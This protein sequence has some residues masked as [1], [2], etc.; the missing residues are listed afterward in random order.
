MED[1]QKIDINLE[2]PLDT[3]SSDMLVSVQDVKFAHN[4]QKFQGHVLPT[5]LR[6]ER[7]GWAAG[8]YVYDF[9]MGGG[10]IFSRNEEP[11]VEDKIEWLAATRAKINNTPTYVISFRAA[12]QKTLVDEHG[13]VI[14]N[15]RTNIKLDPDAVSNAVQFQAWH[16]LSASINARECEEAL[17]DTAWKPTIAFN[18]AIDDVDY[19]RKLRFDFDVINDTNEFSQVTDAYGSA[20]LTAEYVDRGQDGT[21][22]AI[23]NNND[24]RW[25]WDEDVYIPKDL[26]DADGYKFGK[27]IDVTNNVITWK[28]G[29]ELLKYNDLTHKFV[30]NDVNFNPDSDMSVHYVIPLT[31]TVPLH[32]YYS[33]LNNIT[34]SVQGNRILFNNEDQNEPMNIYTVSAEQSDTSVNVYN[35]DFAVTGIQGPDVNLISQLKLPIN[36]LPSN[37]SVNDRQTNAAARESQYYTT[38]G[39]SCIVPIFNTA[40]RDFKFGNEDDD[41]ARDVMIQVYYKY[42]GTPR[43]IG[44]INNRTLQA[45]AVTYKMA[46]MGMQNE[47]VYGGTV[48]NITRYNIDGTNKNNYENGVNIGTK[49]IW[50]RYSELNLVLNEVNGVTLNTPVEMSMKGITSNISFNRLQE[51]NTVTK[52][53]NTNTPGTVPYHMNENTGA[54]MNTMTVV[55]V[56]T[57][58]SHT[59]S[60]T[61]HFVPALNGRVHGVTYYGDQATVPSK[62]V[63]AM[64]HGSFTGL[65]HTVIL[66][67]TVNNK[68]E[69]TFDTRMQRLVGLEIGNDYTEVVPCLIKAYSCSTGTVRDDL[70]V[71][72]IKTLWNR[73]WGRVLLCALHNSNEI[74]TVNGMLSPAHGFAI[75]DSRMI[76]AESYIVAAPVHITAPAVAYFDIENVNGRYYNTLRFNATSTQNT[77]LASM[78]IF[79][80]YSSETSPRAINGKHIQTEDSWWWKPV[81]VFVNQISSIGGGSLVTSSYYALLFMKV[82][83]PWSS[84]VGSSIGG[85]DQNA[86]VVYLP[87]GPLTASAGQTTNDVSGLFPYYWLNMPVVATDITYS[88]NKYTLYSTSGTYVYDKSLTD[89]WVDVTEGTAHITNMRSRLLL[90]IVDINT[91]EVLINHNIDTVNFT[92]ESYYDVKLNASALYKGLLFFNDTTNHQSNWQQVLNNTQLKTI[93]QNNKMSSAFFPICNYRPADNASVYRSAN[94]GGCQGIAIFNTSARPVDATSNYEMLL[95]SPLSNYVMPPRFDIDNDCAYVYARRAYTHNV[96]FN[97]NILEVNYRLLDDNNTNVN[98]ITITPRNVAYSNNDISPEYNN[99]YYITESLI[100]PAAITYYNNQIHITYKPK[101]GNTVNIGGSVYDLSNS[102]MSIKQEADL[103]TL[104]LPEHVDTKYSYAIGNHDDV[105]L[106]AETK[107][108]INTIA[109]TSKHWVEVSIQGI[110]FTTSQPNTTLRFTEHNEHRQNMSLEIT[111][112]DPLTINNAAVTEYSDENQ[113]VIAS[114]IDGDA[115]IHLPVMPVESVFKYDISDNS[116][117]IIDSIDSRNRFKYNYNTNNVSEMYIKDKEVVKASI[118]LNATDNNNQAYN[119]YSLSL[120]QNINTYIY[121]KHFGIYKINCN[122]FDERT[123]RVRSIE[124][125]TATQEYTF[126]LA[127]LAYIGG[128]NSIAVSG[129]YVFKFNDFD[130][131]EECTPKFL[132][133]SATDVRDPNPLTQTKQ[134]A[135]V[136]ADNEYQLI[137]QHWDSTVAT[138]CFWW[139]D[140]T[141]TLELTKDR[142]IVKEK[143]IDG[144]YHDWMGDNWRVVSELNRTEYI[145]SEAD[146]FIVSSASGKN[147]QGYL[148]ILQPETETSIRVTIYNPLNVVNNAMEIISSDV[149]EFKHIALGNKKKHKPLN[150]DVSVDVDKITVCTYSDIVSSSLLADSKLTAVN[151]KGTHWLGIQYDK[152]LNQW[153][154]AFG[155]GAKKVIQGYGCIGINCYATGGMLPAKYFDGTG[156][157]S[158][159]YDISELEAEEGTKVDTLDKFNVFNERIV[160]DENQQWYISDELSDIVMAVD[161]V[162]GKII[163]LPITNKYAQVY[164][165]PSYVK[166]TVHALGIQIKQLMDMIIGGS[167][168]PIWMDIIKY[169]MFPIVWYL[170]PYTNV[171]NY[172]QQ[173][174]GQYAYVHYNSTSVGRQSSKLH[175]EVDTDNAGLT[176]DEAGSHIDALITDDLSFDVQHIAQEQSFKDNSWDN[177]LGIFASMVVSATDMA[178][179]DVAVNTMQNQSA[180]SD[181]GKKFSQAFLQN[182][183][184]MSVTGFTMQSTK[185]MLKSEVTAVKTLDMFY[186]TSAEQNCFAGPGFVNMQFVAQCTA[187]SVTSVQLEAQQTQIFMLLKQL[188]TW[189]GKAVIYLLD[190]LKD[191]M[192]KMSDNVGFNI[193]GVTPGATTAFGWIAALVLSAVGFGLTAA[194]AMTKLGLEVVDSILDSFFPDG[195]KTTVTAQLSRHNYD[196][197]GKHAYGNKSE[198]FFWPCADCK[199]KLYTDESVEAVLQNK[200]WPLEMPTATTGNKQTKVIY[201]DQPACITETPTIVESDDWNGD[202]PYSI[203]MCKGSQKRRALPDSTAYV[204][205]TES[206][207]PTAPFKNENIGEG[208]PVFTTPAVQD[209]LIDKNWNLFVT[210]M[211]GDALWISCKD[212]KLF[213]GNYSNIIVADDFCGVAAPHVAIE[214]KQNICEEYLRPWAVSPDAIALNITG[215]NCAYDEVAYHAFDGYGYRITDWLGASGMNK[216]HYALQYC[217]Q[218]NDRFKRSNKLPPNQFMGNFQALPSMSLDIKDK[219]FNEV[220]VATE[221][222]GLRTGVAGEN[223][224]TQRYSLPIFTEQ[225]SSLPAIVRALSPYKLAVIDGITSLTTDVRV[226]Q[227]VYKI[228]D[229]VDFNINDK[230]YRMTNEYICS[231]KHEKGLEVVEYLVP[232]LGLTYLG[233][234]PFMAYFYNQATRQY[235]IYQGGN[236]LQVM[237]MLERFRDIKNGTYDFINQE[238]VMPC[239]ATMTRLD[240]KVLDDT[241]E[242]DNIV[243]PVFRHNKVGGELTP[244]ITTIFDSNTWYRTVSLASGLAFQ[245]PN[246]C[247]INRFVWSQYMLEDIKRNKGKWK[248]VP[249]EEYHPFRTYS[250]KFTDVLVKLDSDIKGWTHNPFLLVT[251]P[252]GVNEQTDCKFEWEITFAWTTEMEQLYEQ[253][254]YVTVNVMAETMAPGGKVFSRPT[255]IFL[256]KELFTR[257]NNY[258]YYSFR[259]QSN[260]G[261]GNRERLHIWS[262]GYI[263]VSSLQLEYKVISSKRS[264]QLV[265]QEDIKGMKEM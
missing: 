102:E 247:I 67:V 88:N 192:Y 65:I 170:S 35:N 118:K 186:S 36:Q 253:D 5:S 164:A 84:I 24:V 18:Y 58:Q 168:N 68:T 2:S 204:I 173:T 212:T 9:A 72:P 209:Y 243:I 163:K 222:K 111:Y 174:L 138:E 250:E 29:S 38:N 143:V 89:Y 197:E 47:V 70:C 165:S 122:T 239:L 252:L 57:C 109:D 129:V 133:Y 202:V 251:S 98:D 15:N 10:F 121:F 137:K 83:A 116:V 95:F 194:K 3:K 23:L 108:I 227:S 21:V 61:G 22:T 196:I 255:H 103:T 113:L 157:N 7:N 180:T 40:V 248:K 28:L 147:A 171:I 199:S 107:D 172:L 19:K 232:A 195:V 93:Y 33:A 104:Y 48:P 125:N 127:D 26:I 92:S 94:F 119:V 158:F 44:T 162:K 124:Y 203:A 87:T 42:D 242:T 234:T 207:M 110:D 233:A 13:D 201:Q 245:G 220:T 214:I 260:N 240:K 120:N 69:Y 159:V 150:E 238:V 142:F 62:N 14:P 30:Y 146:T 208:E 12:R 249:R 193:I 200:P 100:T 31:Y 235:Y 76:F 25:I 59:D 205:G 217:F 63:D 154:I 37:S 126:D 187:Q 50:G 136:M 169:A 211:A 16:T 71:I 226:S 230:L 1:G 183:G 79:T 224:D 215:L 97:S 264:E 140:S 60:Q 188:T 49:V 8:W 41:K 131:K 265:T 258:G 262:D 231:V 139:L 152:N 244:P 123:V 261:A 225:I 153:A 46:A 130:D 256:Y 148:Y 237:D 145:T 52:T 51:S 181:I 156:F 4:R 134:F 55:Y 45:A 223:K 190:Q 117:H 151:I 166:Y 39:E 177:I 34:W 82:D 216:E 56:A 254:E 53:N 218:I 167:D 182:I 73:S 105:L 149:I 132:L 86:D 128:M 135:K 263:A 32:K 43:S 54:A 64:A 236:T 81:Q 144:G 213:D 229:S 160:G 175:D 206:F 115:L 210:A 257:T 161:L 85:A 78:N 141:H 179:R 189:Q 198:Q 155:P 228:P 6:Y 75:I 96:K 106:V 20:D 221:G 219:V 114:S 74:Q 11:V 246:R 184:S 178:M 176:A 259:Y 101:A 17:I 91:G 27:F 77:Q 241:D 191:L 66:P 80:L 99:K 90:D 112:N 185:P